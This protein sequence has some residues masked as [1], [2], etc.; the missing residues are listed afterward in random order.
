MNRAT[1]T[2]P[3]SEA[4][5]RIGA[6]FDAALES[7]PQRV[8]RRER[9]SVVVLSETEFLRLRA[10]RPSFAEYLLNCPIDIE[11]LP[12]R[13]PARAFRQKSA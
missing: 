12:K 6:L 8:T 5:A 13:R 11:D 3:I 7:G 2:W 9:E 10:T 4:R 1:K